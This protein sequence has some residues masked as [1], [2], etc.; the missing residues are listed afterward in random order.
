MRKSNIGWGIV[1]GALLTAP[2]I[3]L[4]YLANQ[5]AGL[6]F[7]P[8]DLFNW[9]TKVLPGPV[10][11]FG[12]DLMIDLLR[13]FRINVANAAKIAEQMIAVFNF[14]V[15]GTLIGAG[16][17]VYA[18]QG[19]EKPGIAGGLLA[20]ALFGLPMIAVSIGVGTSDLI[21]AVN[22]LWLVG[23]FAI[24]GLLLSWTIGKLLKYEEAVSESETESRDVQRLNRRQF[25]IALGAASASITVV[26]TGLAIILERSEQSRRQAELD[27]S[28]AHKVDSRE[29]KQLPNIDDPITPA[30]GTR[31]EYTPLKNHYKVFIEVEPP[32]ID[33]SNWH[34]PITGLVENP[35]ML[36]QEGLQGKYPERSQYVTL[37]CISGRVGTSLIGTTL[38][39]GISVQDVLAEAKVK[40]EARYLKIHSGDGFYETVELDLINSDERIMFCY[41]WDGNPLPSEHGFPLRIWIPDRYGMK[42]PKWIT[43][44]EVTDEYEEG[45]WVERGWDEVA[46]VKAT[47][48][49]DTVAVNAVFE[50]GG[51]QM[52]PVGGIAF[53]GDRGISKVEVRMDSGPWQEAKLRS[54]LSETTWVIWR[55]DWPF[56]AGAHTFEVRCTEGDGTPQIEPEAKSRPAGAT[57]IHS[58]EANM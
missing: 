9:I 28:M 3:A 12:I 10:V 49:I 35:L 52:V 54:P 55:I 51:R 24:W 8:F 48:V 31:L 2:L 1:V 50:S 36:T 7:I 43:S 41:N 40:P 25:L 19:N 42:Q 6:S 39:E 53:S 13:L 4:M 15:L 26:G 58:K 32:E 44:I 57:G 47:S 37:S 38:W 22:I 33:G 30:P 17:F 46:Q 14:F 45:Y 56:E 20:G 18:S 34:L 5:V 29:G 16:F 23:S 21:P 11:T 27:D